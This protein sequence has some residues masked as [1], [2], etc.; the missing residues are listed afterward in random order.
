MVP[1][2]FDQDKMLFN[3]KNGII[4]LKTGQL[5]PHDRSKQTPHVNQM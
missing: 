2:Q 1:E 5:L 4:Y 3:C